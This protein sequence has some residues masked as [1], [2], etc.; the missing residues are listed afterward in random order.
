MA[1]N[2]VPRGFNFKLGFEALPTCSESE[3][4]TNW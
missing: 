3:P 2:L 4:V 1:K